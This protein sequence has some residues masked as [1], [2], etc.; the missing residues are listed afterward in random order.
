MYSMLLLMRPLSTW[1][2]GTLCSFWPSA[3]VNSAIEDNEFLSASHGLRALSHSLPLAPHAMVS[4]R[5][6]DMPISSAP[7]CVVP[8]QRTAGTRM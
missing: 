4:Q 6:L 8:F 1:V 2:N 5:D 7:L 3:T